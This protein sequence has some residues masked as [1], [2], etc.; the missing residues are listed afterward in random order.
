M[1]L[2]IVLLL[3]RIILKIRL[4]IKLII[5]LPLLILFMIVLLIPLIMLLKI[6]FSMVPPPAMTSADHER[7]QTQRDIGG[8]SPHVEP[9]PF[10]P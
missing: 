3:V 9:K 10:P 8:A 4:M 6:R 1:I 5:L 2:Q 7:A